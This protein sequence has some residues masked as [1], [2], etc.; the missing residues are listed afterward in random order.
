LRVFFHRSERWGLRFS[1]GESF[2]FDDVD[3]LRGG[4]WRRHEQNQIII[5]NIPSSKLELHQI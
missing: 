4:V 5:M 3:F 1:V 2:F